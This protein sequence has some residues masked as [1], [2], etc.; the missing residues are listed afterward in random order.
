MRPCAAN[1]ALASALCEKLDDLR[2]HPTVVSSGVPVGCVLGAQTAFLHPSQDPSAVDEERGRRVARSRDAVEPQGSK[3]DP[4]VADDHGKT[5][6]AAGDEGSHVGRGRG[7]AV[8][9]E[10][11]AGGIAGGSDF[12]EAWEPLWRP[13]VFGVPL[14]RPWRTVRLVVTMAGLPFC[15]VLF[16]KLNS[17]SIP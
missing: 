4:V 15:S 6:A 7:D 11:L 10:G 5:K 1:I 3:R 17:A 9:A 8:R 13:P 2:S 14:F 12:Q 16:Q